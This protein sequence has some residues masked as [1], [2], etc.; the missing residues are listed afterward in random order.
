[1]EKKP[2]S[3]WGDCNFNLLGFEM[4]LSFLFLFLIA[5]TSYS[6][7]NCT[8][9]RA[10]ADAY[11]VRIEKL[12]DDNPDRAFYNL[13]RQEYYSLSK[14][15][16]QSNC[17]ELADSLRMH[18]MYY[19]AQFIVK[20]QGDLETYQIQITQCRNLMIQ[21]RDKLQ[22]RLISQNR[23]LDAIK[24][25]WQ[26]NIDV[27]S[28]NLEDLELN[29]KPMRIFIERSSGEPFN[30]MTTV[31]TITNE[32][33]NPVEV[34]FRAPTDVLENDVKHRRL[35]FL[36]SQYELVLKSYDKDKGFYFDIPLVPLSN[37]V[38]VKPEETYAV[39]FDQKVRY[40]LFNFNYWKQ[41]SLTITALNNWI[42]R[43]IVPSSFC[44][45]QIPSNLNFYVY[46]RQEQ[47]KV[48]NDVFTI[49]KDSEFT[50]IYLPV[51]PELRY[52]IRLQSKK[53][54][55]LLF[56]LTAISIFLTFWGAYY[57]SS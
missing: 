3:F 38:I 29:Y 21:Y 11:V 17:T 15:L 31:L 41:D 30:E 8:A 18:L 45:I 10:Q 34:N 19:Y 27:L 20:P 5:I 39:T 2:G 22:K 42:F 28:S 7:D 9:L 33:E 55:N 1:M 23:S 4:K 51:N 13:Q 24:L 46:D 6:M 25:D 54:R 52:E 50:N 49:V 56:I 26:P 57:V 44:K 47:A 35:M 37:K 32:Q 53:P 48:E 16:L 43:S 40:R 12:K 14:K 36:S